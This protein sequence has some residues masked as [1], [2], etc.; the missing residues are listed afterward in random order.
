MESEL[1]L[2]KMSE[3]EECQKIMYKR[4]AIC[5]RMGL[6]YAMKPERGC[7]D[8]FMIPFRDYII[9][10]IQ[11]CSIDVDMLLKYMIEN[12]SSHCS[13][14]LA[15]TLFKP[16][17]ELSSMDFMSL[18]DKHKII[19]P[20]VDRVDMEVLALIV[21][22]FVFDNLYESKIDIRE[23]VGKE[24]FIYPTNQ[25]GLTNVNG[26][27]FK[28][29]GL[30]FDGKGYYYN[31]F[32]NKTMLSPYD[33]TVGFAKIIKDETKNCDILYRIDE[34]LSVPEAE[35]YD[36]TGVPFAK[37]RGPQFDFQKSTLAGKKTI[38][39]HIDE[40]TSDKLL[41]V[42]K[43]G[44]DQKTNEEFW[45]I[46]IETLPYRDTA[47]GYVIT[48]FLHGMYYP[49]KDMFSHIDYTKNQYNGDV[50]L[51]KYTDSQNGVPIDQY[52]ETRDLHYKIWCIENGEFT[53]ETWYKLMIISL[54]DI[55]QELLNEMLSLN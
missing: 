23:I 38:I 26:A 37:F 13:Y 39:V 18:I 43:Q 28:R 21:V 7:I 2:L 17:K 30:I 35:Y 50:Y 33:K 45:H 29:D 14:F 46:E 52:T 32:T 6:Y 12:D 41:M 4:L 47:N 34:R 31:F 1:F 51:Q 15:I 3:S 49:Q 24:E 55:Y 11:E 54:P 44:S 5:M 53:K 36:Y 40:N 22:S 16:K 9:G 10:Q 27:I 20:F 8:P 19:T 48:T 25:Y 42:I